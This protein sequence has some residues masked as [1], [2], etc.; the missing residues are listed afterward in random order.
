MPDGVPAADAR[1]SGAGPLWLVLRWQTDQLP[2]ANYH[3]SLRLFD[4]AGT[5]VWQADSSLVDDVNRPTSQ[6][7]PGQVVESYHT[8]DLPPQLPPGRYELRAIVYD[9]TTLTPIVQ[10]GIWT[11]EIV[12]AGVEK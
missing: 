8:L 9:E 1:R 3:L 10:V 11:P 4:A 2:K 5:A 12:L 7:Q 6:W